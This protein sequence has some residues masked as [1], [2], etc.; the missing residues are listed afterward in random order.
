MSPRILITNGADVNARDGW[1]RTPIADPAA[2]G[3]NAP[4]GFDLVELVDLYIESGADLDTV[5]RWGYRPI[6]G[7]AG[8]GQMTTLQALINGGADISTP[9]ACKNGGTDD[10]PMMKAV[11]HKK[12]QAVRMLLENG[13]D[14]TY[15]SS[16]RTEMPQI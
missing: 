9:G 7:P 10:T 14:K 16:F 15:R 8:T 2:Y 11:R 13:A 12:M 6:H 4:Y 1:D 3:T 5:D